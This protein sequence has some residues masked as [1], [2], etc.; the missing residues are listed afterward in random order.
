MQNL[1]FYFDLGW[2]MMKAWV[3]VYLVLIMAWKPGK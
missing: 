1:G 2:Q 3:G